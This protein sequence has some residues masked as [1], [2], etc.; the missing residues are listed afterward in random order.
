M[1]FVKLWRLCYDGSCISFRCRKLFS[2]FSSESGVFASDGAHVSLKAFDKYM[3]FCRV[4]VA[5]KA[6]LQ[7]SPSYTG[8]ILPENIPFHD[9]E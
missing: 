9:D 3:M 6:K 2:T 8:E 1:S 7:S 4:P 5:Y